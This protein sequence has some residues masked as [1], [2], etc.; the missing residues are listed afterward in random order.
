ME[1]MTRY[2]IICA[3]AL[4]GCGPEPVPVPPPIPA[5]MLTPCPGWQGRTP[6]T[7]GELLRA[8]LAEKTGRQCANQKIEGIKEIVGDG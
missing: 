5:D 4:A 7:Q 3:L 1:P 8:A 2:L 6:E